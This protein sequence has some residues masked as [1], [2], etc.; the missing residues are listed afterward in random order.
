MTNS[1]KIACFALLTT[2]TLIAAAFIPT[3]NGHIADSKNFSK[4]RSAA[5]TKIERERDEPAME[6]R[7]KARAAALTE[8]LLLDFPE[9]QVDWR[10]VP[11]E[12]NGFF[13]LIEFMKTTDDDDIR[14]FNE[15]RNLL[16]DWDP[17]KARELLDEHSDWLAEAI[18]ISKLNH[19]SGNIPGHILG[20]DFIPKTISIPEH[21]LLLDAKLAIHD[22][23]I[24]AGLDSLR[25]SHALC[26]HLQ[27]LEASTALLSVFHMLSN[28]QRMKL[29]MTDLVPNLEGNASMNDL[30]EIISTP[31]LSAT[32]FASILAGNWHANSTSLMHPMLY[33]SHEDGELPDPQKTAR[34]YAEQQAS[35]IRLLEPL[36][37]SMQYDFPQQ[38]RPP[39]DLS[40]AGHVMIDAF[41][42]SLS[43]WLRGSRKMQTIHDLH[44]AAM[45]LLEAEWADETVMP[46]P[47]DSVTGLPFIYDSKT[48]TLSAPK[49][50]N[51]IDPIMLP[52]M[53]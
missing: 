9:L 31:D 47:V 53:R 26:R 21:I 16:D 43:S 48:R 18:G 38:I 1:L 46:T 7:R 36:G 44:L 8:S 30:R 4:F 15:I 14:V 17:E 45:D 25:A 11:P 19:T 13:Q 24:G 27:D 2:T 29:V 32:W 33:S 5:A 42:L 12:E 49:G 40:E 39:A 34:T 37:D 20:G 35:A 50:A 41:S 10:D 23:R 28:G 52:I 51:G 22:K 3:C 6:R